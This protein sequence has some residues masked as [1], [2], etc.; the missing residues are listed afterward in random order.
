MAIELEERGVRYELKMIYDSLL[1]PQVR[2]WVQLHPAGFITPFPPR[3]VNNIYFDTY[4]LDTYNDHIESV[5]LR[6]K[7]RFRWYGENLERARGQI[8]VKNK[9]E[10]SGWKLV[11][12]VETE[13]DLRDS[14]WTQIQST[15]NRTTDGVFQQLL[16]VSRP[17]VINTYRREYYVSSDAHIRLTLDED[18]VN[19]DQWLCARPNLD[20]A[21]PQRAAL[22]MELKCDLSHARQLADVLASFPQRANAYS[23][24]VTALDAW[25]GR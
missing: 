22:I 20:F 21:T 5:N 2:S 12:Q 15:L 16:A 10:R 23:K 7:L 24:F 19:Y 3:R 17:L 6:R 1:A 18:L 8:E 14:D 4:D 9:S 13:L 25:T 11:Q